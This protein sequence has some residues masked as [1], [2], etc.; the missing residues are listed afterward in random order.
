M[1]RVRILLSDDEMHIRLLL[2]KVV[3]SM[4]GEVVGEAK[5]GKEAVD[6]YKATGPDLT[7]LDVNMPEKT[8]NEALKEI[9]E[10][11]PNAVVIMLTSVT[12]MKCVQQCLELGAA[13]YIRKDTPLQ[14]MKK[15]IA[16]AFQLF[17]S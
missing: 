15:L 8:G 9:M 10:H 4:N 5:D 16:E 14:E 13:S 17:K 2:K 6:L 7:L 12:D 1:G 11:D 3:I